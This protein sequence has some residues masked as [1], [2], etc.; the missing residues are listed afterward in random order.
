MS[1]FCPHLEFV[2]TLSNREIFISFGYLLWQCLDKP[3][4]FISNLCPSFSVLDRVLTDILLSLD[5]MWTDLVYGQT[6]D[7]VLTDFGQRLDF[8]SNLCPKF[9]CPPFSKEY[10]FVAV[11]SLRCLDISP[12]PSHCRPR[13]SNMTPT[14]ERVN[15]YV[16][17][18]LPRQVTVL[19]PWKASPT[20]RSPSFTWQSWRRYDKFACTFV[21]FSTLFISCR[22]NKT[23]RIIFWWRM[24]DCL[25]DVL[26]LVSR[27]F[28]VLKFVHTLFIC[29]HLSLVV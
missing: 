7:R 27:L 28:K 3:W 13:H 29:L 23:Q 17:L 20:L 22:T 8:L 1:P 12:S 15:A 24:K 25:N 16:F 10:P 21:Y 2:L 14:P 4:I 26:V 9:V 19:T 11:A 6:L 18:R 5:S